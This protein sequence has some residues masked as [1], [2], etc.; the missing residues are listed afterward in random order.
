MLVA[1]LDGLRI[2]ANRVCRSAGR[3]RHGNHHGVCTRSCLQR[4]ACIQ[5]CL[6]SANSMI[7]AS[8]YAAR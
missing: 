6:R 8:S 2:D 1:D 5:A 4:S 7:G 3:R